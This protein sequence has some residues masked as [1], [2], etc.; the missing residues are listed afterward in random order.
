MTGKPLAGL[1]AGVFAATLAVAPGAPPDEPTR[2]AAPTATAAEARQ[3]AKLLHGLIHDTLQVVHARY[4]REGERLMIPA[5]ALKDVFR[6]ME[7]RDG[8]RL[9]WLVVDGKAMN[10]DHEPRDD[11][12]KA[13]AE[14]LAAG[15]AGHEAAEDGLYRF[16]GPIMLKAECLKCHMP[17]R[18]SNRPRTAGLLITIPVG[19]R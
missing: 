8:V 1:I 12:E 16:A 5:A 18:S 19:E 6:E 11:F 4:F 15:E 13:A 14:A 2:E 17:S 7:E 10:I 9:R 3:R